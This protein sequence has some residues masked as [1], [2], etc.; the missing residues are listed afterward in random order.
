MQIP[1]R[2]RIA[3]TW[4]WQNLDHASPPFNVEEAS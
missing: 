1:I 4:L 2:R 3:V